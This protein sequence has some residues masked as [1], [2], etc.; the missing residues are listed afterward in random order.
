[1]TPVIKKQSK[2]DLGRGPNVEEESSDSVEITPE[3]DD[4]EDIYSE[5]SVSNFLILSYFL[6]LDFINLTNINQ[7][8]LKYQ[9]AFENF[10]KLFNI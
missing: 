2:Y 5:N 7:Y 10:M 3:S 4:G 9:A 1:M 6:N 8:L